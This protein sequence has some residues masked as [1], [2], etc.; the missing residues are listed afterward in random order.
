MLGCIG[1]CSPQAKPQVSSATLAQSICA[2]VFIGPGGISWRRLQTDPNAQHIAATMRASAPSRE[3]DRPL[4]KFS[5]STPTK[6]INRPMLSRRFGHKPYMPENSAA[7]SG[8]LA[9]ATA[10]MPE[11]TRSSAK[12]TRPLP[13]PSSSTPVNA[14]LRHCRGAGG[15]MPR[16]R[17]NPYSTR[18]AH[19]KRT[20]AS[21]NGG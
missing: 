2:A 8:M 4:P 15:A 21:R 3:P 20:P 12:H 1:R 7:N 16:Q 6:P 18:P 17:R 19:R 10:A 5:T 13:K 11:L 9:T 14:A